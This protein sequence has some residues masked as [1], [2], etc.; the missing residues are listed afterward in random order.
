MKKSRGFGSHV[1]LK[2]FFKLVYSLLLSV[3]DGKY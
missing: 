2:P 1:S 3:E